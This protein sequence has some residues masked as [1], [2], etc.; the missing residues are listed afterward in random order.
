MAKTMS[1]FSFSFFL[2]FFKYLFKQTK[3]FFIKLSYEGATKK[4]KWT[5]PSLIKKKLKNMMPNFWKSAT[6]AAAAHSN[7]SKIRFLSICIFQW[8]KQTTTCQDK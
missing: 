7:V 3:N 8:P 4:T 6:G 2:T 1:F 5:H